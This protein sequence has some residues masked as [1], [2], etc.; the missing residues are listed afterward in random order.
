MASSSERGRLELPCH[1]WAALPGETSWTAGLLV[2]W[3][4]G[5]GGAWWGEVALVGASGAAGLQMVAA[6][7]LRPAHTTPPVW[8]P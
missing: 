2:R 8:L 3:A 1:V 5:D 4:A 6:E 7:R